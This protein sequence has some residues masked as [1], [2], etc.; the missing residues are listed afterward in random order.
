MVRVKLANSI[1]QS[2]FLEANS[3]YLVNKFHSFIEPERS[4]S[5]SQDPA[6]GLD[7]ETDE[8]VRDTRFSRHLL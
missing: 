4:L 5:F 8:C 3:S 2:T 1:D 7:L 6:F